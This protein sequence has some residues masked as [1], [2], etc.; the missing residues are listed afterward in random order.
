M[1]RT[2]VIAT[3]LV[4]AGP[5]LA[6]DKTIRGCTGSGFAGCSTM[7]LGKETVMLIGKPGAVMPPPKTYVIATGTL[8]PAGPNVCRATLKMLAGKIIHTRRA[9]K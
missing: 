9:C 4:A 3:M 7:Q 8:G 1:I 2:L 6:K 5:A